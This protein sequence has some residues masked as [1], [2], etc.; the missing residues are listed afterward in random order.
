MIGLILI[1]ILVIIAVMANVVAPQG[2]DDQDLRKGLLPPSKE[3]PLGTDELG[4]DL[5]S[6]IIYGSRVSLEV[7][8]LV[9]FISAFTG[10]SLGTVGFFYVKDRYHNPGCGGY[11]LGFQL[12]CWRFSSG[13]VGSQHWKYNDW[14]S[15][16]VT[17]EDSRVWFEGKFFP[18][19]NTTISL[20]HKR[21]VPADLELCSCTSFPIALPQSSSWQA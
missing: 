14:V 20:P 18:Y 9:T 10:V 7:A 5:L 11:K 17:G 8:I 1:I 2:F 13:C 4:R 3:F 21:L 12:F 16:W 15:D 19:V 6:R